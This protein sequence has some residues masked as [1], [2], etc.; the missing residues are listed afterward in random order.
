MSPAAK[1]VADGDN[2][3]NFWDRRVEPD[4]NWFQVN[5]GARDIVLARQNLNGIRLDYQRFE[6]RKELSNRVYYDRPL[7][8]T[9]IVAGAAAIAKS[10]PYVLA[11]VGLA[12]GGVATFKTYNHPDTDRDAFLST[13]AQLTCV[14]DQSHSLALSQGIDKAIY[15]RA[16]VELA[17]AAVTADVAPLNV[18]GAKLSPS[19]KATLVAANAALDAGKKAVPAITASISDYNTISTLIYA[20]TNR[21]DI[22][23]RNANRTN[24]SYSSFTTEIKNA[25]VA[26]GQ[27]QNSA[28]QAKEG[29]SKAE[30]L[31]AASEAANANQPSAAAA[32][33][34]SGGAEVADAIKKLN[35]TGNIELSSSIAALKLPVSCTD[36]A[37]VG[38]CVGAPGSNGAG[39]NASNEDQAVQ[40]QQ[41]VKPTTGVTEIASISNTDSQTN[42][43]LQAFS[44][45]SS[46]TTGD[47]AKLIRLSEISNENLPSPSYAEIKLGIAACEVK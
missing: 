6:C 18:E 17:I 3:K 19:Q 2:V 38:T 9:A 46:K 7:L 47:I 4:P 5:S 28:Q 22:A 12:A 33:K 34:G 8:V 26:A 35:V 27:S 14:Y 16:A 21:I 10:N 41:S 20:T 36:K 30:A 24:G 11:G 44:I 43:P 42:K 1:R 15:D 29:A 37:P 32:K 31:Q 25:Y 39:A 23:A 45:G 40:R 13:Y